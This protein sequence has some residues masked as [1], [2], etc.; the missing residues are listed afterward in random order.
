MH[1]VNILRIFA[2]GLALAIY[3]AFFKDSSVV[4]QNCRA[5]G[6]IFLATAGTS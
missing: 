2:L 1:P 6:P 5:K 4:G 3:S